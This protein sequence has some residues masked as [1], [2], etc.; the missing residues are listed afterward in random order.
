MNADIGEIFKSLFSKGGDSNGSGTAKENPYSK[1]VMAGAGV[2][3]II[4]C[5]MFFFAIPQSSELSSKNDKVSQIG[6]LTEQLTQLEDDYN[7]ASIELNTAQTEFDQM[8]KRFFNAQ[9]LDKLYRYISRLALT[10]KILVS[11]LDKL[12]DKPVFQADA[13][14]EPT[15]NFA[16]DTGQY[17]E[18]VYDD[19]QAE[20]E[21]SKAVAYYRLLVQLKASGNFLGWTAFRRDLTKLEKI[22][23]IENEALTLV[24]DSKTKGQINVTITLA[25]FRWP[26]NDAEKFI[27]QT[28][29]E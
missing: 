2:V 24:K 10:H 23:I 16:D 5:Y 12:E 7:R 9:D 15:E 4:I 21:S 3:I 8:S 18:E 27:S 26:A 14:I 13:V 11:K 1:V 6:T 29:Y 25:T 20:G 28:E 19:G 17:S 22:I